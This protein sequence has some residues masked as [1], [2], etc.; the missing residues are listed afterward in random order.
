M[1]LAESQRILAKWTLDCV[2]VS[3]FQR[4]PSPELQVRTI[5]PS[6]RP[7][8]PPSTVAAWCR[9]TTLTWRLTARP[10]TSVAPTRPELLP[11]QPC[12]APTVSTNTQWNDKFSTKS[13]GT[14][15]NQQY[16][17]CDWWFNVDCS[18]VNYRHFSHQKIPDLNPHF[19]GCRLL[20]N[21]RRHR[22]SCRGGQWASQS[23]KPAVLLIKQEDTLLFKNLFTICGL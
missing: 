13:S 5:P 16:F 23:Q 8:Q 22:E 15:Y 4:A 10:T 17:V 7:R 12:F 18:V 2:S 19:S 9:A 6:P 14:L 20:W 3:Y 11:S 1:S 21:Q